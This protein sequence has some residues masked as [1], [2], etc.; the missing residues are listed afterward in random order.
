MYLQKAEN[1]VALQTDSMNCKLRPIIRLSSSKVRQLLQ[2]LRHILQSVQSCY[3]RIHKPRT[4]TLNGFTDDHSQ[5]VIATAAIMIERKFIRNCSKVCT[6]LL[7][8]QTNPN[9]PVQVVLQSDSSMNI[10]SEV[11]FQ[12]LLVEVQVG[13][14]EDVVVDEKYRGRQLGQR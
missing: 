8:Q 4:D 1:G 6:L 14:I 13:H 3:K 7:Q 5:R 12:V 2:S 9:P 11:S 10:I